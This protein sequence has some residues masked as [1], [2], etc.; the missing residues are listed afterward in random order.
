MTI[1]QTIRPA[2]WNVCSFLFKWI[3]YIELSP[4]QRVHWLRAR[5]QKMR[6][7]EEVTLTTYEMQWT[8]RYFMHMS[9]KWSKVRDTSAEE[10]TTGRGAL[11]YAKRKQST[12]E[13]LTLKSDRTFSA[14]NNAYKSPL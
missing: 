2:Y 12:W 6:W 10:V 8:A 11:A 3:I 1:S 14:I 4:V 9:K 5:A 13:H 7:H